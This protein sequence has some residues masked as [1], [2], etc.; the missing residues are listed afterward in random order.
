VRADEDRATAAD[1]GPWIAQEG[2]ERY[3]PGAWQVAADPLVELPDVDD[4][5]AAGGA[6]AADL[7]G[8]EALHPA[9]LYPI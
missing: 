6:E 3:E 2:P 8:G 9:R 7:V 4:V 5:D 1:V